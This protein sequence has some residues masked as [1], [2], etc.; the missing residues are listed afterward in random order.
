MV[1]PVEKTEIVGFKHQDTVQI[2]IGA[3]GLIITNQIIPVS[4]KCHFVQGIGELTAQDPVG[5]LIYCSVVL[6]DTARTG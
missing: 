2:Q 3:I 6:S 5:L 1:Q 4:V